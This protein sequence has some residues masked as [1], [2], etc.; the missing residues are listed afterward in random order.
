LPGAAH[1][2]TDQD[3]RGGAG[4]KRTDGKTKEV[5]PGHDLLFV[6]AADVACG[7]HGR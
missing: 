2:F 1:R 3:Q 5:E 7:D 6:G 4:G